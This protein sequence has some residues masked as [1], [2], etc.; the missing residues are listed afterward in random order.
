MKITEQDKRDIQET[1]FLLQS[2]AEY[3][4]MIWNKEIGFDSDGNVDLSHLDESD[5]EVVEEKL[6]QID[7][8]DVANV[9]LNRI[10]YDKE[11][12]TIKG[13]GCYCHS[14]DCKQNRRTI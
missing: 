3:L 14:Y 12:K 9:W 7:A 1:I 8:I 6:M 4:A 13:S 11:T 10:I 5:K 2:T